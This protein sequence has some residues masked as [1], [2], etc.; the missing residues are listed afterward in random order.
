LITAFL[1]AQMNNGAFR[2]REP[3]KAFFVD[4]SDLLNTPTVIFAG[5][6]LARVGLAEHWVAEGDVDAEALPVELPSELALGAEAEPVVLHAVVLDGRMLFVRSDLEGHEIPEVAAACLLKLR[7]DVVG[8]AEHAKVDVL[9]GSRALETKLEHEAAFQRCS[10][11]EHGN[12]ACEEAVEHDELTLARELG[13][14][15]RG[16]AEPLLEGLL[17]RLWR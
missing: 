8:R 2:S 15:L 17:E 1:L 14:V 3:A 11:S 4:V 16:G 5:K 6:L 9:R 7:E 12:D 13:A 10:I